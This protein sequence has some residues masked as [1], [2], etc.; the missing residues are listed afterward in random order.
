M[1]PS[2][3]AAHPWLESKSFGERVLGKR[4][5]SCAGVS[6]ESESPARSQREYITC[7]CRVCGEI[8]GLYS[9][10]SARDMKHLER[11]LRE[12]GPTQVP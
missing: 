8:R 2:F 12:A 3:V 9:A 1:L 5:A 10:R 7:L 6:N 4:S 11:G